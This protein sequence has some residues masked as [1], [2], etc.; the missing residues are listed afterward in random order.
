MKNPGS[1][2]YV[3]I[4]DEVLVNF[5]D[6]VRKKLYYGCDVVISSDLYYSERETMGLSSLEDI[7]YRLRIARKK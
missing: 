3:E 2:T 6:V 5:Q 7:E 1:K 4:I